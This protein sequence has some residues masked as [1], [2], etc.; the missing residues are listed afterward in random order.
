MARPP[1][2]AHQKNHLDVSAKRNR[3]LVGPK[4]ECAEI[5]CMGRPSRD[6]S[7]LPMPKSHDNPR[8]VHEACRHALRKQTSRT[9][10]YIIYQYRTLQ[11][12]TR[13]A[14]GGGIF[15]IGSASPKC[16]L[17]TCTHERT[18]KQASRSLRNRSSVA[19]LTWSPRCP[20]LM[21]RFVLTKLFC[22]RVLY[23]SAAA[24]T[25]GNMISNSSCGHICGHRLMS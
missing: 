11:A 17:Q 25:N 6:P 4:L 12:S 3:P 7:R 16:T 19:L 18:H 21:Q 2:S 5:A 23:I 24:T 20:P 10:G 8:Q 22:C 14:S 1:P 15:I 13:A 9:K